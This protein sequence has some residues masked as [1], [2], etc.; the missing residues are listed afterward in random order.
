RA[1]TISAVLAITLVTGVLLT[2]MRR[3]L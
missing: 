3:L 2:R 1:T